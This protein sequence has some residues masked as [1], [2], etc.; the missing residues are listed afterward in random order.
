MCFRCNSSRQ[1]LVSLL[2]FNH[3]LKSRTSGRRTPQQPR[4]EMGYCR[5]LIFLLASKL[6]SR[7]WQTT[8]VVVSMTSDLALFISPDPNSFSY[9]VI[10]H[11]PSDRG[12]VSILALLVAPARD[13]CGSLGLGC[14][15]CLWTGYGAHVGMLVS[16]GPKPCILKLWKGV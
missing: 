5:F 13:L 9:K 3:F 12:A 6:R 8:S 1:S 7:N 11:T 14:G 15:G 2:C 16:V 4:A 10:A